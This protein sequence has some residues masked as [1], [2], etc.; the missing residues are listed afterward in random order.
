[1]YICKYIYKESEKQFYNSMPD[2]KDEKKGHVFSKL[3]M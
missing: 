1:M 3:D 2:S